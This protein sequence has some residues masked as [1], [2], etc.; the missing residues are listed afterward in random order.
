MPGLLRRV[1][2]ALPALALSAVMVV[3]MVVA[4]R[5]VGPDGDG[6]GGGCDFCRGGAGGT[7][8][9]MSPN[10]LF[11]ITGALPRMATIGGK[12][13]CKASKSSYGGFFGM[14][15]G[16]F[17]AGADFSWVSLVEIDGGVIVPPSDAME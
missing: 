4:L 2:L 13:R 12:S 16:A 7:W 14:G 10:M 11:L 5:N 8:Q 17:R 3:V 6:E 15:G 1:P 9:E